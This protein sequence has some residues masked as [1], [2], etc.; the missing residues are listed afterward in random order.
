MIDATSAAAQSLITSGAD[1]DIRFR[2]GIP[3]QSASSGSGNVYFQ[4]NAPDSYTWVGLGIGEGMRDADIFLVYANGSDG[5]TLSTRE[6]PGHEMPTYTERDDVELLEGSGIR[7]G[8]MRAN[9]R[10][11]AC[12][13]LDLEGP[14]SWIA[15]WLTG[16]AADE[17]DP[18]APIMIHEG[19]NV[20]NVNLGQA[21]ISSDANPFLED[22]DGENDDTDAAEE[23]GG[24]NNDNNI[25]IAHGVIMSIVFVVLYPLGAML[26]PLIGKW[27]IH[28]TSQIVA[29]LL[30]WAGF[31]LGYVYADR[32]GYV[33]I[34]P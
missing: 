29:F 33:S 34:T 3:E 11:G 26:M 15:A 4:I 18:E 7:D 6:A 25:I 1:N 19:K 30:M 27:F 8:R 31:A 28:S 10:C 9:I 5:V 24:S 12:D 17:T 20:F 16:D 22:Q 14:N 32:N 13:N 21:S 23:S 2:W